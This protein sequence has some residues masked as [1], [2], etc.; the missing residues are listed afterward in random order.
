IEFAA[1]VVVAMKDFVS[2]HGSDRAVIGRIDLGSIEKWWLQNTCREVDGVRLGVLVGIYG[3]RSHAPLVAVGRLA[4]LADPAIDLKGR[5]A[6]RIAKEI[7]TLDRYR[8]VVQPM[9]RVTDLVYLG[10]QL[11]MR[12]LPGVSR[13]PALRIDVLVQSIPDRLHHFQHACLVLWREI[14]GN[15][16]LSH[17]FSQVDIGIRGTAPPARLDLLRSGNGF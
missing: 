11:L 14:T 7:V 8:R 17:H 9:I 2:D 1:L 5:S 12:A 6:L 3:G 13:H 15:I 16:G 10:S 4:N